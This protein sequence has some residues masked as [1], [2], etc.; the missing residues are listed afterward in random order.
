MAS[1]AWGLGLM[2]SLAFLGPAWAEEVGLCPSVSVVDSILGRWDFCA[3]SESPLTGGGFVGVVEVS[4]KLWICIYVCWWSFIFRIYAWLGDFLWNMEW[5]WERLD[6][7]LIFVLIFRYLF[8]WGEIERWGNKNWNFL[9]MFDLIFTF[10]FDWGNYRGGRNCAFV[11]LY[12][13][14]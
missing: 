7:Y 4:S 9:L 5:K 13:E 8:E 10:G 1:R 14:K 6:I 11:W 2:L 3:V 12:E